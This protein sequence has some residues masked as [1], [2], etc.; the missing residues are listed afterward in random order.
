MP[1]ILHSVQCW[2]PQTMTWLHS[3]VRH[4]APELET[5][6][7]CEI[8]QNLEQFP[9]SNLHRFEELGRFRQL[10]DKLI[11]R[12][13]ITRQLDH[14][15]RTAM[16]VEPD[17]LHSHFGDRGWRDVPVA[18]ALGVKHVVTFYGFDVNMLP[19]SPVWR[20][21]YEELFASADR[22]LCEGPH[23]GRCLVELGCPEEKVHVQR[24]G[25]N[26]KDIRFAPRQMEK[27]EELRILI[28]GTFRE[29]KGIPD[30]LEAVGLLKRHYPKLAVTVIGDSTGQPRE[31]A[32]KR[33]IAEVVARHDLV[34]VTTFLG[35]QPHARFFEEAYNNHL[36]LSPSITASDGDTEGGAPVTLIEMAATGIPIVS[37]THCDIP[38]VVLNGES[39]ILCPEHAPQALAEAM[40]TLAA[41]PARLQELGWR[42]RKHVEARFDI[43]SLSVSLANHYKSLLNA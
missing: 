10:Q 40:H 36:F 39:G 2:L 28:A 41:T 29:K 22:F 3:L 24:L 19:R 35:F 1:K 21:R 15:R 23:M 6:V 13:G 16:R 5:H 12:A 11:R 31:E 38:E 14:V 7:V 18:R 9:V 34:S 17:I 20:K 42:G 33:R 27:G 32:E 26:V 30:A 4:A 8:T 43:D 37:T 25:I